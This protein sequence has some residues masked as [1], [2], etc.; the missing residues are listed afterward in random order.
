M[1]KQQLL[2]ELE[3]LQKESDFEYAHEIADKLLIE[4]INDQEIADA[5]DSIGKWYA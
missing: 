1:T 2:E 5:F 3:E 4:Y